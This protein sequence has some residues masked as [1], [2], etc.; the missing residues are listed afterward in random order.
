VTILPDH[1]RPAWKETD[2]VAALD[3]YGILDTPR[4]PD[5]DDIARLAAEV[6]EAPIAVVNLIAGDRQW[7]KAE[8]G[9][10]ARE[11]PLSVSI[12]AHAILQADM[13]IVPDLRD[14][15]RFDCN[16]LVTASDGALRFYAGALLK[17]DDGLP[18]GTVCVLDTQP[19]LTGV[20]ERQRLTLEVLARQV[21]TQLELRRVLRDRE[22]QVAERTAERDRMWRLSQDL[23]VTAELDGTITAVNTAWTGLLGWTEGEL[24]GTSFVEF[25]HPDDLEATL[26]VFAGISQAPLRTPYEYR[27]RHKDGGYR[28]FA[29]TAAYEDGRVY[30]NGRHTTAERETSEALRLAEDSLRQSQ[31]M[32]AVGQLTGGVAHDFNNLLTVIRG[33]VELLRRPNLAE[34]R[35]TRYI[36]AI[37]D[38]AD[39]ATKLTGQ[40]LS[41]A[42]RQALRPEAFDV[43]ASIQ[44]VAGMLGT[45]TGSRIVIEVRSSAE[46]CWVNADPS[47]FDT[48]LVNMAVNARDAMQGEGR[49]TVNVEPTSE[50]PALRGHPAAKGDFVAVSLTDTGSGIPLDQIGRIF[51]PFF[52]TK[53]VGQ[54]TGLGLSQVF[55][56][57]KQSGGDVHVRSEIGQGATFTMYLPRVAAPARADAGR[58]A[59]EPLVDGGGACVLVVE[60]NP[61]VGAF[62]TQALAELGYDTLLAPSGSAALAELAKDPSRFHVVFT[63]VVMPGMDGV[64]LGQEIRRRHQDLPVL[65]TSGYSHVLAQNGTHG[66]ELLHKPYSIEQLSRMLRKASAWRHGKGTAPAN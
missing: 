10:G 51:E 58:S 5:F 43:A 6:F 37:S 29:W 62:A 32:E 34:E 40:L 17:T 12:C 55:G 45:L 15:P 47:Q 52:T 1:L 33:S 8:V 3:R 56:F 61:D 65:L 36:D 25:T 63:D 59:P 41:F 4:E 16:P 2:R 20:S 48:A 26:E 19:R 7:F 64:E 24:V 11:L 18:I 54:G 30:A 28:W 23:L 27:F 22:S 39:R 66:F 9:I 60:D 44:S 31:K 13:L 42:R 38:T 35:R 57:A 49:L 46:P 53:S 21:M 14:D 50:L